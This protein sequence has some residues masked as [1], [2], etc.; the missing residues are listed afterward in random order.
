[1]F[2][3]LTRAQIT[4]ILHLLLKGT[5]KLLAKQQISVELTEGA[6]RILSDLGYDPQFGARPMKR[7]LQKEVINEISKRILSGEYGPGDT[8]LIDSDPKGLVFRTNAPSEV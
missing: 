4:S 1:M 8:I 5:Q 2:L 3:P 6:E 7:V